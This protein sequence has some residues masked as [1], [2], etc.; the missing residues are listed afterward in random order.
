[1]LVHQACLADER[2]CS[3]CNVRSRESCE[4]LLPMRQCLTLMV[5]SHASLALEGKFETCLRYVPLPLVAN[6]M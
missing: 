5:I 2:R 3:G 4:L 1:M 6:S